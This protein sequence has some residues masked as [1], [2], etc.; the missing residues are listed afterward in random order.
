MKKRIAI[1]IGGYL[2]AKKYGGPVTS[3]ANLVEN[4][5][6]DFDFYIISNDHEFQ[7]TERL[8]GIKQGWNKVGN[9]K[10]LYL[11]ES[12]YSYRRFISILDKV[13]AD[14]VY[15][16]SVFYYQ[17]NFPAIRAANRL[18]IPIIL[19]PRGELCEGA[20]KIGKTKKEIFLCIE[21]AS[22]I[23]KNTYFQATSEDEET[24]IKKYLK[25]SNDRIFNLPNM[26]CK[27]SLSNMEPKSDDCLRL[28]YI[29][30][31]VRKKNV[32]FAIQQIKKCKTKIRFDIYGPIE[33]K[34]YW[35]ECK[36]ELA[37][38]PDNVII[39][40]RGA[41]SPGE[42]V[43]V[44]KKYNIFVFPTLS[45]NYGHVIAEALAAGCH[46]IVSKGTTPWDDIHDHGGYALSLNDGDSWSKTID[47]VSRMNEDDYLSFNQT[48]HKYVETKLLNDDLNN[49]YIDMFSKVMG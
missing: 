2:P 46:L 1:F 38:C 43:S 30:R 23:F 27:V 24:A 3:I 32:L 10:V 28:V 48:L 25:I 47:F 29:S 16:S 49:S 34:E 9:G 21:R 36:F 7:E 8:S 45:E 5:C 20:M 14:M 11:R 22:K 18:G 37:D 35:E 31:L 15:L 33:D 12:E 17:M 6:D 13:K 41:I 39:E 40:Y 44:F 42:S 26:A 4:L 19:A